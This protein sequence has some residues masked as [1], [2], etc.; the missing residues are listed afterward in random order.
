MDVSLHVFR[1]TPLDTPVVNGDP[2]NPESRRGFQDRSVMGFQ[3]CDGHRE[4]LYNE[5]TIKSIQD[6]NDLG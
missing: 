6:N 2:M 4:R 3:V 5:T 1:D